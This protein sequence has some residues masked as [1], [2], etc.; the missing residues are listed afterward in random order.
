MRN[1]NCEMRNEKCEMRNEQRGK[2]QLQT[3]FLFPHFSILFILLLTTLSAAAQ[4]TMKVTLT[5]GRTISMP[6][7]S[8]A[9][10]SVQPLVPQSLERLAGQWQFIAST[11]GTVG[12]DGIMHAS[13]DTISFTATPAP[14]GIG[15]ICQ[16]DCLYARTGNAV[17]PASWRLLLE[18]DAATGRHRLGWVLDAQQPASTLEFNE[19][20]DKYLDQGFFYWGSPA[21]EH[22]Y[23]YLLS[24]NIETQRLE[25]MTLW[26]SWA[27]DDQ[28]TYT[29]PQNQ[30]VFG[31]VCSA[32]PF[33]TSSLVGYFEI[34]AS[35][36]FVKL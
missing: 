32:I 20:Q 21:D 18:E 22:H 27:T 6:V 26:S 28:T 23:I 12:A 13:T 17:Y 3:P 2:R 11:N 36:R 16:A 34:W 29:F 30:E 24:E 10:I 8:I 15:L 1:V 4:T 35:P 25:G 9:D 31:L 19:P 14:D 33:A 5:D 7:S